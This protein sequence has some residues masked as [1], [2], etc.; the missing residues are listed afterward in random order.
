MIGDNFSQWFKAT[1]SQHIKSITVCDALIDASIARFGVPEYIGSNN[2]V[3][4]FCKL[5]NDICHKLVM[6]PNY[7]TSY[8]PQGNGKV[9]R[10]NRTLADVLAKCC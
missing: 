8:H 7:S 6:E 1:H 9:E 10:I 3:K 4:F 5:Y 2:D